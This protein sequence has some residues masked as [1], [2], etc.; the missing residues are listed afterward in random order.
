VGNPKNSVN[1]GRTVSGRPILAPILTPILNTN[2]ENG[3]LVSN[4]QCSVKIFSNWEEFELLAVEWNAILERNR[5]LTI[6]STPEWLGAWWRAFGS[7]NRLYAMSFRNAQGLLVGLLP[8]YLKRI[9]LG[10]LPSLWELRLVGD[11]SSDS[12]NLDFVV[13]PG[14]ERAVAH[15]LVQHLTTARHWDICRLN[16]MP[17]DSAVANVFLQEISSAGWKFK[18]STLPWTSV[19]LPSTWEAYL[20]QLSPKERKKVG[21][22]TRRVQK[23]YRARFYQCSSLSELP[24]CLENLFSLHQKRWQTRGKPGVFVSARRQFY[25]DMSRQFLSRGWLALWMLEL[26]GSVVAAQFGFRYG[27]TVYSLQEGFDPAYSTDSIGY[28]LRSHSLQH[29][30]ESGVTQYHFLAGQDKSKLRWKCV[31]GDYLNIHF[32]RPGTSASFYLSLD[33]ALKTAKSWIRRV[34][35]LSLVTFL[36][37]VRQRMQPS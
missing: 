36:S 9:E 26:D 27:D 19:E 24:V 32:A 29:S 35:P 15:S 13:L 31:S 25:Y 14:Y 3:I 2:H 17:S 22:L 18:T 23:R 20:K 4:L 16:V 33:H 5:K 21:N 1:G 11:G 28:V 12:D 30:I 8:L 7:D 10:M 37:G 34:L 6:F